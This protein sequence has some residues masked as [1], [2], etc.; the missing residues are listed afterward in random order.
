M[1]RHC[2]CRI[3]NFF[4]KLFFDVG[5]YAPRKLGILAGK[6]E[7]P[8]DIDSMFGDEIEAMFYGTPAGTRSPGG[9]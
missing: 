8:D 3:R 6:Y 2:D 9:E 7:V 5:F 1:E 4:E